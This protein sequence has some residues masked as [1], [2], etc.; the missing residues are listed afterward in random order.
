MKSAEV[1]IVGAGPIGLALAV[2]LKRAGIDYL[3]FDAKQIGYTISWFAP[4]TRFFSSN[5]RIA[6]AG[7][8]LQTADQGKATREEYLAYLRSIVLQFDLRVKTY[9]PIVA[10]ARNL[11]DDSFTLTSQPAGSARAECR[12]NKVILATGGTDHP[13]RLNIPG[14]NL[15]HVSHYFRDPH[16]YFGKRLLIVGGKNS[17]VEATLRCHHLG[18]HVAISYRRE[19]LPEKSIKYWL[20]P[21]MNLLVK[22]GRIEGY[23]QSQPVAITPTHVTLARGGAVGGEHFDVPADFVLLLTGY[24]QD[25]TL[26]KLAGLELRGDCGAPVFDEQTMQTSVPSIYVAG[27]AVAGTQDK[28]TLFIENC[29]VH[30]ERIV[31]ALTGA[32]PPAEPAPLAQPES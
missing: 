25:N 12:V 2:A 14:E 11:D 1:A 10:L 26:F 29:H 15:P 3:H 5:E 13:R 18:A 30:V 4:Q 23:F 21:E 22:S 28:Y 17:A 31:S 7:V 16:A 9:E 8:P 24:E 19:R 6:I 27:T 20:L 32:A